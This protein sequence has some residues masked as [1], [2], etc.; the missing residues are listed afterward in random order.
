MIYYLIVI[1]RRL[2]RIINNSLAV[3]FAIAKGKVYVLVKKE[4][5]DFNMIKKVKKIVVCFAIAGALLGGAASLVQ[6]HL[7]HTSSLAS[8]RNA[9]NL[10]RATPS[11]RST[12]TTQPLSIRMRIRS[13][14]ITVTN[15]IARNN[16]TYHGW[17]T[18][19]R[20]V[21]SRLYEGTERTRTISRGFVASHV[22]IRNSNG[23]WINRQVLQR[24]FN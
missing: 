3:L 7:A 11:G 21:R 2:L 17:T 19:D 13:N 24:N 12:G 9:N 22:E 8:S 6:A 5:G 14:A 16:I 10:V 20:P 1:M 23:N 4:R 18:H 15:G